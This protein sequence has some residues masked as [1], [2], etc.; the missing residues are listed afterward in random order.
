MLRRLL[1]SLPCLPVSR[2]ALLLRRCLL[3]REVSIWRRYWRHSTCSLPSCTTSSSEQLYCCCCWLTDEKFAV[4]V[5]QC[6][7]RRLGPSADSAAA[8]HA[9]SAVVQ[10]R[11][12]AAPAAAAVSA[13]G[14][15]N[16]SDASAVLLSAGPRARSSSSSSTVV[17]PRTGN[18]RFVLQSFISLL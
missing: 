12:A 18:S 16:A 3:V 15:V 9:A 5:P 2:A 14:P 1:L 13:R 17:S 8:E 10:Q 7:G 6:Q 4:C 11:G